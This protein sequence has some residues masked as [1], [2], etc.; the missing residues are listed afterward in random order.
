MCVGVREETEREGGEGVCHYVSV[1]VR[2]S[3]LCVRACERVCMCVYTSMCVWCVR[4]ERERE[5]E[6]E[7]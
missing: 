4:R 3:R 7:S 5:R 1:C 2:E 6:R